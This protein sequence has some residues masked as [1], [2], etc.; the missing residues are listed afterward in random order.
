VSFIERSIERR[1]NGDSDGT[2][3]KDTAVNGSATNS[4]LKS[5]RGAQPAEAGRELEMLRYDA[6]AG[7]ASGLDISSG[8]TLQ[9]TAQLRALKRRVLDSIRKQRAAQQAPVILVTSAAPGDG[10]SFISFHLACA[11]AKEPDTQVVLIDGDVARQ[12]IS[13][14][15]PVADERGLAGCLTERAPL[16]TAIHRTDIPDLGFVPAG[17]R[18]ANVAECLASSRWDDIATEMR[19]CGSSRIFV[20]D[21]APVLA[22][23]ETEYLARTA[24]LVLFVIRAEVTPQQT[25]TEAVGRLSGASR[26]AFVFNGYV[27]TAIDTHYDYSDYGAPGNENSAVRK[28]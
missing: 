21:T 24:D 28:P 20:V 11:L 19:A 1:K 9:L 22:S 6:R 7:V 13:G 2:A 10:K 17:R 16:A 15:F 8:D 25:V 18:S 4:H 5:R 12:K 14:L 27:N 26:V 3:L 23:S